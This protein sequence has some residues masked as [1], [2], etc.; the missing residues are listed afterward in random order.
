MSDL[1][2]PAQSM[3]TALSIHAVVAVAILLIATFSGG[4]ALKAFAVAGAYFVLAG[5]WSWFRARRAARAARPTETRSGSE[6][7]S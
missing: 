3:R 7:E 1:P 2:P 6:H 5:G 4:E